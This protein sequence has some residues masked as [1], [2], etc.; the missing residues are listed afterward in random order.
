VLLVPTPFS[1][2]DDPDASI[3]NDLTNPDVE[4]FSYREAKKS[5]QLAPAGEGGM[6][7]EIY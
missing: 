5:P 2:R 3:A 7:E 6:V 1:L 4:W